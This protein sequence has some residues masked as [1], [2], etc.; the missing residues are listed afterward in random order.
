MYRVLIF[1]VFLIFFAS[2][3]IEITKHSVLSEPVGAI[4]RQ[5][6]FYKI[7]DDTSF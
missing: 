2:E 3:K 4:T 5:S 1:P 6:F 7:I